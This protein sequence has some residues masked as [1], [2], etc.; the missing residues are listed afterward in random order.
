MDAEGL[1]ALASVE[2]KL[3]RLELI[4]SHLLDLLLPNRKA[5]ARNPAPEPPAVLADRVEVLIA[6]VNKIEHGLADA[7]KG[8]GMLMDAA[9]KPETVQTWEDA[10]RVVIVAPAAEPPSA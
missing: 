4:E 6:K 3:V 8:I 7:L 10:H 1:Q 2:K 9:K 5:F